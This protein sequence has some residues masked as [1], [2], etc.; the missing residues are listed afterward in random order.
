MVSRL[1]RHACNGGGNNLRNRL[2]QLKCQLSRRKA[3]RIH[4]VEQHRLPTKRRT[5]LRASSAN[6]FVFFFFFVDWT[7]A[8]SVWEGLSRGR[9]KEVLEFEG[10]QALPD[11]IRLRPIESEKKTQKSCRRGTQ[12]CASFGGEPMLLNVVYPPGFPARE[13]TFQ[14]GQTIA[15]VVATAIAGMPLQARDLLVV[16]EAGGSPQYLHMGTALKEFNLSQKSTLTLFRREQVSLV[17]CS[18]NGARRRLLVD[19]SAPVG[20]VVLYV[21]VKLG[22]PKYQSLSLRAYGTGEALRNDR[23]LQQHGITPFSRLFCLTLNKDEQPLFPPDTLELGF[24]S[25]PSAAA[26][27]GGGGDLAAN[28]LNMP[29]EALTRATKRGLLSKLNTKK[30]KYN[31]RYFVLQDSD[32]YYY[33]EAKEKRAK[34]LLH[35]AIAA[36][37]QPEEKV[38]AAQNK[39]GALKKLTTTIRSAETRFDFVVSA[40]NKTLRLGAK[41]AEEAASWIA[42]INAANTQNANAAGAKGKSGAIFRNKLSAAVKKQDGSEIPEVVTKS[43]EYLDKQS[44]LKI[45]GLFRLSGSAPVIKKLSEDID[46]GKP[47]DF[48][49]IADPH[50]VTGLLKLYFREM[51]EPLLTWDLYAPLTASCAV[52]ANCVSDKVRYLKQVVEQL[53]PLNRAV[54][55]V[56]MR[57]LAK[58]AAYAAFNK[59][60]L[61]NV[62]VVFAS[63]I[64][65]DRD[66]SLLQTVEASPLVNNCVISLLEFQDYLLGDGPFPVTSEFPLRPY[67]CAHH[68]YVPAAP[69]DLALQENDVVGVLSQGGDGWWYGECA[70]RYGRFPGSY[71]ALLEEK[72]A[73]KTRKKVKIDVKIQEMREQAEHRDRV[74]AELQ[75]NKAQLE[76]EIGGLTRQKEALLAS[77][78][79]VRLAAINA[80]LPQVTATAVQYR[81]GL[82]RM[83][84]MTDQL[85]SEQQEMLIAVNTLVSAANREKNAKKYKK[86]LTKLEP[87]LA[88]LRSEVQKNILLKRQA[89]EVRSDLV[90]DLDEMLQKR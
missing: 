22:V 55:A 44:I 66:A 84:Q 45:V 58:V 90:K 40:G 31:S 86:V 1:Q 75:R 70:G 42:A 3:R 64:L 68:A 57:F 10:W 13:L 30:G 52:T 26:G 73:E 17:L 15:Q 87:Q 62:A 49:Q 2:A 8:N 27:G 29:E 72:E 51:E 16:A 69:G 83:L 11:R 88:Q 81:D 50:T 60:P 4:H 89:A 36:A 47:V 61:H 33:T 23:S 25:S 43:I 34:N 5:Q 38:A 65:R 82:N 21:A 12:L 35:E 54:L 53:P 20:E 41:S 24:C 7:P 85:V 14:L 48:A 19:F 76:Q 74:I 78:F 9:R 63:N 71:L 56:L 77:N 46:A 18:H 80:S 32:L 37:V 67:A 79:P 6:F 39:G 28:L 59:M